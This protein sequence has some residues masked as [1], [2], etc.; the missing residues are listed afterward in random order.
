M[1]KKLD[2]YTAKVILSRLLALNVDKKT[3]TVKSSDL[4]D[5]I[6]KITDELPKGDWKKKLKPGELNV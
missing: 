5:F 2:T 4:C 3:D 6:D 1:K